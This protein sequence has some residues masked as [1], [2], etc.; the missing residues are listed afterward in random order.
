MIALGGY[1]GGIASTVIVYFVKRHF[2][3]AKT[4]EALQRHKVVLDIHKQMAEQGLTP[5]TLHR[6]Q[7]ILTNASPAISKTPSPESA[8][9]LADFIT[10]LIEVGTIATE[11]MAAACWS[12]DFHARYLEQTLKLIDPNPPVMAARREVCRRD[13][14]LCLALLRTARP[15]SPVFE[16]QEVS[17]VPRPAD[18]PETVP[19]MLEQYKTIKALTDT[20]KQQE[21]N[22]A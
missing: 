5:Q 14:H 3:K 15:T 1:F 18:F 11:A 13:F 10:G 12:E 21:A 17:P 19:E 22:N 9:Q 8:K 2:E 16:L 20:A 4:Q 6:L 7:D